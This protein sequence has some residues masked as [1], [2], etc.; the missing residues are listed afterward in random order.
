MP[1]VV[2]TATVALVI[3]LVAASAFLAAI[4]GPALAQEGNSTDDGDGQTPTDG[5]GT[6]QNTEGIPR[7]LVVRAIDEGCAEA[8]PCWDITTLIALPGDEVRV[9]ADFTPSAQP[10]NI[11]FEAPVNL[12]AP[13]SGF[14]TGGVHEMSFTVPEDMNQPIDFVCEAH[15]TTMFGVL[16]TPNI[17]ARGQVQ[18][19]EV[20]EL[21]VH[22]LAYWVGL[23]AF[24]ILFLVYGI[25]FFLFKYNETSATTDHWD[26][27][28]ADGGGKRLNG[29][30]AS[31][32]AV[33]IAV[34]A[35]AAIIY[36]A[37]AG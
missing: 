9:I 25:T 8:A 5:N 18:H 31:L 14:D 13:P 2:R 27:T 22:F 36:M 4:G 26:R 12:K 16:T 17:L 23:I 34:A 35:L 20:P 15:P 37:R 24:A 21:G 32:L 19:E 10:H 28:G 1:P 29:G 30:V 11:A 6:E 33:V 7:T 3:S